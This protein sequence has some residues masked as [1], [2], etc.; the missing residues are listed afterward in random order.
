MWLTQVHGTVVQKAYRGDDSP[1][2]DAIWTD[3]ADMPIAIMTADCLPVVLAHVQGQAVGAAHAGWRGLLGGVLES[4]LEQLPGQP[5]DYVAWLGPA[6]GPQSFEVGAEVRAAFVMDD[7]QS[8]EAF[9]A[10]SSLSSTDEKWMADLYQLARW[11]LEKA[12]L[13][14][15]S[16]GEYCTYQQGTDFF[17][18]RREGPHTG[19]L[20]T[21]AWLKSV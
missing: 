20:A 10:Q 12:G 15:V 5:S 16:G 1:E 14:Q 3:Q 21:V 2:A 11:R 17:S 18:H 4:L 9:T 7:P 13:S 19:R 8:A 6:I